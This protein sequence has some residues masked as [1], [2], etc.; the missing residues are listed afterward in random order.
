MI[1][2]NWLLTKYYTARYNTVVIKLCLN[3]RKSISIAAKIKAKGDKFWL[4]AR[5]FGLYC[6]EYRL[7]KSQER[8]EK[9]LDQLA[10]TAF[11]AQ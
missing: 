4:W 11:V 2:I 5:L 8:L 6:Q 1:N 9:K 10:E 7:E 3:R